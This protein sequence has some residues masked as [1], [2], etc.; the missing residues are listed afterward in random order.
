M[1]TRKPKTNL[2]PL[3]NDLIPVEESRELVRDPHSKAIL[4]INKK[5][6]FRAVQASQERKNKVEEM[7]ALKSEIAELKELV[8]KLLDKAE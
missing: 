7:D 1:A 4:N 3:V 6:Y 8:Q 2:D 5:A